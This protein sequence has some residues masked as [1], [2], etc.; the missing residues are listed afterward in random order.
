[1]DLALVYQRD[2]EREIELKTEKKKQEGLLPSTKQQQ[3]QEDDDEK[4][5]TANKERLKSQYQTYFTFKDI[6]EDLLDTV[7]DISQGNPLFAFW[8]TYQAIVKGFLIVID[9]II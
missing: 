1:M 3:Q 9:N 8:Y 6:S 5:T 2:F 7:I 4:I